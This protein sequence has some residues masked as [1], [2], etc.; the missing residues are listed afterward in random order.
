MAKR[1]QTVLNVK[2]KLKQAKL[3]YY[4]ENGDS[5]SD[6]DHSELDL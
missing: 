5:Q 6:D 4:V 3:S 2:P 1:I